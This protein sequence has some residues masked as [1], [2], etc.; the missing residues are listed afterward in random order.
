MDEEIINHCKRQANQRM[1]SAKVKKQM[2]TDCIQVKKCALTSGIDVALN[3]RDE[4]SYQD[5]GWYLFY[6][7]SNRLSARDSRTLTA[8][9]KDIQLF[10]HSHALE[11]KLSPKF[12]STYY[13]DEIKHACKGDH[14]KYARKDRRT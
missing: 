7:L 5:L 4:G 14:S 8:N 11:L 10:L 2:L 13:F 12:C 1:I 6:Y 9:M 3:G